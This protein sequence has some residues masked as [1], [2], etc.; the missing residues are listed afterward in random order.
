LDP[1]YKPWN[2]Y[3]STIE[4]RTMQGLLPVSGTHDDDDDD[5]DDVA[6]VN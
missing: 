1:S 5:D 6:I 2:W 4:R 3:G